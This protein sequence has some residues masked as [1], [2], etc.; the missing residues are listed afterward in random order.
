MNSNPILNEM[1]KACRYNE[2]L[3]VRLEKVSGSKDLIVQLIDMIVQIAMKNY[4][5]SISRI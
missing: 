4:L 1:F 3:Y 2:I 5:K